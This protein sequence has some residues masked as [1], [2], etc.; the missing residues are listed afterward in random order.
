MYINVLRSFL[1]YIVIPVGYLGSLFLT[2]GLS[3]IPKYEYG[4]DTKVEMGLSGDIHSIT[5]R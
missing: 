5:T 4:Q 1:Q 2:H 3:L